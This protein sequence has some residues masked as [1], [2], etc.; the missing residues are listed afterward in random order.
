MLFKE[1]NSHIFRKI[2]R[3]FAFINYIILYNKTY[4]KICYKSYNNCKCHHR[5]KINNL[6]IKKLLTFLLNCN[7]CIEKNIRD[8][9]SSDG[10]ERLLK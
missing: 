2:F 1:K 10:T 4:A 5:N 7:K 3:H 6:T 9:D 8:S